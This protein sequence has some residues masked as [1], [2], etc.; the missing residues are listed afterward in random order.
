ML[1]NMRGIY[2]GERLGEIGSFFVFMQSPA[3]IL[4]VL[5]IAFACIATP[6]AERKLKR[7]KSERIA[8]LFPE[9]A[10]S[11]SE[12]SDEL[13]GENSDDNDAQETSDEQH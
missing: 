11:T 5:L 13:S 10:E 1:D 9:L 2:Y 6:I 7:A 4:C 8:I 3:G 12:N